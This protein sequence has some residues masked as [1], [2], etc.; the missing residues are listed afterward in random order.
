MAHNIIYICAY[1]AAEPSF[2][3][4]RIRCSI[5]AHSRFLCAPITGILILLLF[6]A[7]TRR[8]ASY[9]I[10]HRMWRASIVYNRLRCLHCDFFQQRICSSG[11][12]GPAQTLKYN[13]IYTY[14]TIYAH[15][16]DAHNGRSRI[17]Y[18]G[19]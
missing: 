13:L 2:L 10:Y 11:A 14:T 1:V 12:K 17:S 19:L 16:C 15:F 3:F 18:N 9:S 8:V 6:Y 4:V 7:C 5:Y